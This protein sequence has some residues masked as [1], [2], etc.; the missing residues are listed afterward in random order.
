M[1]VRRRI[2]WERPMSSRKLLQADDDELGRSISLQFIS[3]TLL[4]R[5]A[6]TRLNQT[7]RLTKLLFCTAPSMRLTLVSAIEPNLVS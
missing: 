6:S 1:T 4:V 5:L 3:K 2:L 7:Q